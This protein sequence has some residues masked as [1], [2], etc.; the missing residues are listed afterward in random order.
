[1]MAHYLTHRQ[2]SV[3]PL[4]ARPMDLSYSADQSALHDAV[5]R[6]YAKES[7][8]ERVR[9]AE[10]TGFDDGLWQALVQMGLPTMGVP[11]RLGGGAADLTD[12]A[13]VAEQHGAHLGSAPLVET[14]VVARLLADLASSPGDDARPSLEASL[15]ALGEG[16]PAALAL[17][18]LAAGATVAPLVPGASVAGCIVVLHG[19]EL[20]A[21]VP[22]APLP[23]EP[24]LHDAPLADVPLAPGAGAGVERTVLA[25]GA[26]AAQRF[27][28]ALDEWRVLQATALAGLARAA[29][30]LGVQYAKDRRQFG[31][32][33]GSF[34]TIQHRLAD[35]HAAV[36]GAQL[37]A[38]EAAWAADEREP[39]A[40]A[41]AAQALWFAGETAEEAAGAS[42][43]FHGGYGFMLEYDVQLY[44]RRA[45]GWRL[46]LGDPHAELRT[47][48]RRR[49]IEP[50][51]PAPERP[52]R[53]ER[54]GM[55][56]RLD[57]ETVAFRDEVREFLA[58]HLTDDIVERALSTGTMH[59]WSLHRKLCERGYL[60]AGWPVEVGGLGRS[61]VATTTLM[62]E[63]YRSGA[64]VDG[65][66][67]AAMVGATLLL[68][69][70]DAQRDEVLPR[71]LTGEV[72]CCLGYSEP[73]AGSDV[74]AVQTRA[75]RD[76]DGWV[77]DG[78]K[79]FTTMAHEAE[80]VFL[81]TR[82]DPDAPKHKG[83]TMFLVPMATPGIEVTP[84][85][86]L[87]GERTNITFYT[88]VRV[89][90]AC[91]VGD[92]DDGWSVMHAA[93]V[94]ERNSAN[95]GEPAHLVATAADWA[96]GTVAAGGSR[97]IDD[98]GVQERL[99]RWDTRLEV[100]RLLLYRS[101]W[102]AA[103]GALPHVE[104]SMAKLVLTEAF[105]AASGD[106]L[107][108]LGAKGVIPRAGATTVARGLLEHAFRHAMVTT[109]YG[110]S[111]EV[112]REIIAQRGLGLPR[113]R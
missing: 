16:T 106:V 98:P 12:L 110:G 78:Q 32:P 41:L 71:I 92:V 24:S 5:T 88:E 21:L 19:D 62:Q 65:M 31:V 45:K 8:P 25:R 63:L 80:Y 52:A 97:P 23:R 22:T 46:V 37:L 33:I 76:G 60:A 85:E 43:H 54:Q 100:G 107:D 28:A 17:Q 109:I 42:L 26:V 70:T 30:D 111:S 72:L 59:D 13:V 10:P 51:A 83:L 95:W 58:E 50:P 103:G 99:A 53:G 74:A 69:G 29:L 84:V 18:P 105:V 48:A 56:F 77:I 35:L 67:I 39:N 101:A 61:A 36:D 6:L 91:R 89:P 20:V 47:I 64:P 57:A 82:T 81:L 79:M 27:A 44:A 2:I 73:D 104:G 75:V 87:G 112:Q 40:A 11:E 108:L 102:M 55:D 96:A 93:L 38:Y 94:Y 86:T 49:W 3:E 14:M 9:G 68:R 90:D 113:A 7:H 66:G 1:M 4:D 34:Q 15:A